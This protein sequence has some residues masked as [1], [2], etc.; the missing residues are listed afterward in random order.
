MD[1]LRILACM[2]VVLLHVLVST[3][4]KGY[5]KQDGFD[6]YIC[7]I[8]CRSLFWVIPIFA[9]LTGLF[10]LNEDKE[11][12]MDKLYGKYV[13]RLVLAIIFWTIIYALLLHFPY[14]PFTGERSNLWYIGVCIG[15]YISMPLLRIIAADDK[16]LSYSCW[17]WLCCRIY[18]NL[19]LF[20]VMPFRITDYVF[21]EYV[22]YCLWGYY[23]SR[24][25]LNQ[26]Q[27]NMVYSI[28][29]LF[30]LVNITMCFLTKGEVQAG[31]TNMDQ[32]FVCL[33]I[34][35]FFMRHPVRLSEKIGKVITSVS[36]MTFG[37]CLV[38]T[39]V[40][41]KVFPK[42]HGFVSNILLFVPVAF[43]VVFM[44]CF[45]VIFVI[46]QIPVLKNWVV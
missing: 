26:I 10:F 38:H 17:I 35:L 45:A 21:T 5:V 12:P 20:V 24:M 46:K 36:K 18:Y 30:L 25:K 28:G 14:Y 43:V 3:F 19:E 23:L 34:F 27:S 4:G 22:G 7:S 40:L 1:I 29:V 13:L 33:A 15:L 2:G 37:I 8:V 39:M 9:M 16:L 44:G 31:F 11:L 32:F 41:I 6:W 42:I